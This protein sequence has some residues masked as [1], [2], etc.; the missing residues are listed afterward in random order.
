MAWVNHG[1]GVPCRLH[2]NDIATAP[3]RS[4]KS[5]VSLILDKVERSHGWA[6]HAPGFCNCRLKGRC[7][8]RAARNAQLESLPLVTLFWCLSTMVRGLARSVRCS[9]SGQS[10]RCCQHYST[11]S[12]VPG[13]PD[14]SHG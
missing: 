6:Q 1:L 2:S 3:Y 5:H 13:E 10:P 12:L 14:M 7:L 9:V 8:A 11:A 4:V